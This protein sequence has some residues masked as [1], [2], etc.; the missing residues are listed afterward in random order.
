MTFSRLIPSVKICCIQNKQEADLAIKYG[1]SALGFVSEMPSGPG[2]ISDE[3]IAEIV[4]E[5]PPPISTF[6]L[7][8]KQD[9][10][11][12]VSQQKKCKANTLQ[13]CDFLEIEVLKELREKLP[14]VKFIQVIHVLGEE[15]IEEAKHIC[16]YVDVILLDSGNPKAKIKTLGGTGKTHNWDVSKLIVEELS[17]PVFLAGG[18]NPGNIKKAIET[19]KPFA[20]DVCSGVRTDGNLDERKLAEFFAEINSLINK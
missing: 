5:I 17:K 12:I 9:V 19:V 11:S 15:S 18:L 13:F 6:L 2:S 14:T 4:P 3:K 20:V 16:N 8:S 1:A 10:H 7:T